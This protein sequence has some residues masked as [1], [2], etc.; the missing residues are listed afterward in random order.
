MCYLRQIPLNNLIH[1][2]QKS[3]EGYIEFCKEQGKIPEAGE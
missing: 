1:A 2:S 3:I